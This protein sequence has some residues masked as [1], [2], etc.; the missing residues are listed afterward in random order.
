MVSSV[1]QDPSSGIPSAQVVAVEVTFTEGP[2]QIGTGFLVSDRLVITAEHCTRDRANTRPA[3]RIRVHSGDARGTVEADKVASSQSLDIA[4]LR[5]L[6][7]ASWAVGI[8]PPRYARVDRT[9]TG[10]LEDCH[11]IGYPLI[12][13]DPEKRTRDTAEFHGTIYQTDERESGRLLVREALINPGAVIAPA[14]P[15][16]MADT[17]QSPT[18]WD[19]MS[20]ALVF[21]QDCALGVVIEHHPRQGSSALLLTAFDTLVARAETDP[22]AGAVATALGLGPRIDLPVVRRRSGGTEQPQADRAKGHTA[23]VQM[24]LPTEYLARLPGEQ[25]NPL[26]WANRPG[27]TAL[28]DYL[29]PGEAIAVLG[30]LIS[31]PLYPMPQDLVRDLIEEAAPILADREIATFQSLAEQRPE[32]VVEILRERIGGRAYSQFLDR[33]FGPRSDPA[34]GRTWTLAH[35][36]VC[37]CAFKGI[38]STNCD[39]GIAHARLHVRPNVSDTGFTMWRD[40]GPSLNKW[41]TPDAF[42]DELPILY[43]HGFSEHRDSIVFAASDYQRA[44]DSKLSRVLRELIETRH[45]VWLGFTLED[46]Q[47]V[48]IL[49]NVGLGSGLSND[50]EMEPRHVMVVP[51]DPAGVHNDPRI[52][53]RA[54]QISSG[55]D[56]VLYPA[57]QKDHSAL[58][59]L[60]GELADSDFPA[61]AERGRP[62][63]AVA[64]PGARLPLTWVPERT[65]SE[66][67]TGRAEELSIL[68]RWA[69]DPQVSV[70]GVTAIGG[71]G[72]TALVSRWIADQGPAVRRRAQGIFGW[73]FLADPSV[74]HWAAALRE[75]AGREFGEPVV[76]GQHP[77]DAV[78]ELLYRVPAV[79]VLDGLE[80]VQ[81]PV[82]P[83]APDR[84]LSGA[85]R[86]VLTSACQRKHTGLIILT[87]RFPF[88]DLEPFEGSRA[89][90][91]ELT[92]L[93]T[94]DGAA[95]LAARGGSWLDLPERVELTE[96]T[97]RHALTLE[98]LAGMLE[99]HPSPNDL[100]ELRSRL[101]DPVADSR[102]VGRV[103]EFRAQRLSAK[104]R[105]L[106]AT[107]SLFARP[108]SATTVLAVARHETFHGTLAGWNSADV[109]T[110]ARRL[111]GLVSV[112]PDGTLST[113]PLV[114]D[115]FRPLALGAAKVAAEVAL[116]DVPGGPVTSRADALRVVESIELLLAAEQWDDADHLYRQRTGDGE[117]WLRLPAPRLGQRA[118]TAFTDRG[119]LSGL[120]LPPRRMGFYLASVGLYAMMAGE[121]VTAR[122]YLTASV[123]HHRDAN[124][125]VNFSR[126]LCNLADCLSDLGE[127][128]SAA[129]AAA[130][131]LRVAMRRGDVVGAGIC[132]AYLGR[133]ACMRGEIIEAE[134]HFIQADKIQVRFHQAGE[135]LSSLPG[136]WWAD[137]LARTGRPGPARVLTERNRDISGG[138]DRDGAQCAWMLGRL[139]AAEG[140]LTGGRALLDQAA[141]CFREGEMLPELA[142]LLPDM[143]DCARADG[144]L[145][146]A[147]AHIED[148]LSVAMPR[149]ILP[150]IL[151]ALAV[152]ASIYADRFMNSRDPGFLRLGIDDAEDAHRR[153]TRG[154][155]FAWEELSAAQALARLDELAQTNN[156][157]AEKARSLRCR[158]TPDLESDPLAIVMREVAPEA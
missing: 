38:I 85:L 54:A 122:R 20:G 147:E 155:R 56:L 91:M 75:W 150:S 93:T 6:D 26:A 145:E 23:P 97:G 11:A 3:R 157:W 44:Y 22:D 58:L 136:I 15:S 66:F 28:R 144:D 151:A 60:L 17:R 33:A 143:A 153:A 138:N 127:D 104:E 158:L 65:D 92:P 53:A 106:L 126:A 89:R 61:I 62:D 71:S 82:R 63:S 129:T 116:T 102:R 131:A 77:A 69:D 39:P 96:L 72:K 55:A 31:A 119:Q 41:R 132:H 124:D 64:V 8:A 36:L 81:N 73:S 18:P 146:A 118:A 110:N 80:V 30:P 108:V 101:A 70:I 135:H 113:H 86:E 35:E 141:D 2:P 59:T 74:E 140:D 47:I 10:R 29:T 19:G 128:V 125:P 43:A 99:S 78:L 100:R 50:R 112:Q 117:V 90:M 109:M 103:L 133:L 134:D 88:P 14:T 120:R 154:R 79:L 87:S 25:R 27:L 13:R 148:A 111:D 4:V 21:Y 115:A 45:L 139:T 49:R 5:L 42:R 48:T 9:R 114:R 68:D 152:R 34:S 149:N 1:G 107:I 137:F 130:E 32:D 16:G 12:Q 67:F 105:F 57:P 83:G 52:L 156:G 46:Q 24:P 95:L 84:L 37:R 123:N 40:D 94:A 142:R 121:I 7:A 51:W 98:V 76:M